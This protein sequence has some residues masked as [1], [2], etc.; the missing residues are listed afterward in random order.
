MEN[1]QSP[2]AD[3]TERRPPW[4][5]GKLIGPKPPCWAYELRE[6]ALK[7][8]APLFVGGGEPFENLITRMFPPSGFYRVLALF[9][10]RWRQV[11]EPC[12]PDRSA[13]YN[14]TRKRQDI[15]MRVADG[16]R[17]TFQ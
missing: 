1:N 10:P 3:K 8:Q 16:W 11:R 13:G 17:D 12:G 2:V 14:D 9:L 7:D 5:K 6:A 4:N 15:A